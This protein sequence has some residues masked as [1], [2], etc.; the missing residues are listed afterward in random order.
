M[1]TYRINTAR[2]KVIAL[3]VIA[4]MFVVGTHF[5]DDY[6]TVRLENGAYRYLNTELYGDFSNLEVLDIKPVGKEYDIE[7]T[8]EREDG[9]TIHGW[10]Y[11]VD[12]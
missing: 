6:H 11:G 10:H 3:I 5:Y 7:Y 4:L 9:H 2:A 8:Y 12:L 1:K